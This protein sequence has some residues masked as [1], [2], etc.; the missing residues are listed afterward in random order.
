LIEQPE[1]RLDFLLGEVEAEGEEVVETEHTIAMIRGLEQAGYGTLLHEM[2]KPGDVNDGVLERWCTRLGIEFNSSTTKAESKVLYL[3]WKNFRNY[4]RTRSIPKDLRLWDSLLA[5]PGLLTP[6]GV[7]LV[8]VRVPGKTHAQTQDTATF[9]CP[10]MGVAFAQQRAPPPFL[11]L[12][13]DEETGQYDPLVLYESKREAVARGGAG[14]APSSSNESVVT[15]D[16]F[17]VLQRTASF[18]RLAPATRDLLTAFFAEYT[19][20]RQGCGR[21]APPVHPWMPLTS[22]GAPPLPVA[23]DIPKL[24][25]ATRCLLRDRSN[26]LVGALVDA[27]G[28]STAYVPLLDD[29]YIDPSLPSLRGETE[30]PNTD[31]AVLLELYGV[32]LGSRYPGL[33]PFELI[34]DAENKRFM[35]LRLKSGVTVPCDPF[36]RARVVS[37]PLYAEL[38][39]RGFDPA[40]HEMP[41]QKDAELLKPEVVGEP[42]PLAATSEE[43]LA[44]S[45]ELLRLSFS[46]W[47]HK[48]ENRTLLDHIERLRLSRSVLPMWEIQKRLE[49]LLT[50]VVHDFVTKKGDPA[51]AHADVLRR[52]CIV[53]G[54]SECGGGCVWVSEGKCMI[55]TRETSRYKNPLRLLTVRLVDE[56]LQTF[57]L[58]EELLHD[59]VSAI[60]PLDPS[61]VLPLAGDSVLFSAA[62]G[63]TSELL[64]RLGYDQRKPTAFTRGFTYPEEVGT[65]P[66]LLADYDPLAPVAVG[67]AIA[68]DPR[69]A[70]IATLTSYLG[71]TLQALEL[72]RGRPW[73]SST[74]DWQFIAEKRGVGVILHTVD[75]DTHAI[76][77]DRVVRPEAGAATAAAAGAAT[78]AAGP[79]ERFILV[80][81]DGRLFRNRYTSQHEIPL[82]ELPPSVRMQL[83]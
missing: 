72:E 55:H 12:M 51:F 48:P 82:P 52:D 36:P 24:G 65:E 71:E 31:V 37:H 80:N 30:L 56:L 59:R 73:T 8:I 39:A 70:A 13:M 67:A 69:N 9:L 66:E 44:E 2:S 54:Q 33:V 20:S 17:G 78:G 83:S 77:V 62:G 3:A 45:Y 28:E 16:L 19:N 1:E 14:A 32:R 79:A 42:N 7:I 22:E 5:C 46:R 4:V 25:V 35:A 38:E 21:S 76:V 23:S 47:L 43:I 11:F 53:T 27:G 18:E 68:R 26:R 74:E 57:D 29:G 50:P 81:H 41:W 34:P 10:S 40:P 60:K 75:P 64:S 6:T 58:A 15:Y 63:S 49:Y 61:T